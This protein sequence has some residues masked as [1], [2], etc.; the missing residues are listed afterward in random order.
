MEILA[1]SAVLM[2][3]LL[4]PEVVEPY[5]ATSDRMRDTLCLL[6]KEIA[7]STT[8]DFVWKNSFL[9]SYM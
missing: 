1:R 7:A 9:D 4:Q 5:R 6:D 2:E 8:D 3:D